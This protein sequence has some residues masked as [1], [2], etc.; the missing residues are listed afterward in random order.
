M[1][2][3]LSYSKEWAK[4]NFDQKINFKVLD[5]DSGILILKTAASDMIPHNFVDKTHKLCKFNLIYKPWKLFSSYKT[6][7]LNFINFL[8]KSWRLFDGINHH[9][10]EKKD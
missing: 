7:N 3:H 5:M 1:V 8:Q 9:H 2:F 4:Y 10:F 6:C